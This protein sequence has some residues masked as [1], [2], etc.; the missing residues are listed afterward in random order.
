MLASGITLLA[1]HATPSATPLLVE[2]IVASL[3]ATG[4]LARR[5]VARAFRAARARLAQ[6]RANARLTLSER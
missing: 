1:A 2:L 3:G 6:R 5:P 4:L